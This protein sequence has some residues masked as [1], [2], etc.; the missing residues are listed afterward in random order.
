MT[1]DN[2]IKKDAFGLI[3]EDPKSIPC[4]SPLHDTA[5]HYGINICQTRYE[6]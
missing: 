1:L 3:L 6:A 2:I 4:R 5:I